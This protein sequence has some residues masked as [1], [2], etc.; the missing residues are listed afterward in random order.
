MP[1]GLNRAVFLDRDGTL[2]KDA[3]YLKDPKKIEII[4]GVG[5]ALMLIAK[6]GF[7]VFLHTN[8]SGVARGYYC[9]KDVNACNARMLELLQLPCDFFDGAC[10]APEHPDQEGGYRKPSARFQLE[11]IVK[12]DLSPDACWMIGDKWIDAQAGLGSG[13]RAALVETGKPI[14]EETKSKALASKVPIHC[15]LLD[16]TKRTLML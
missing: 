10:I 8:Q 5:E 11:T 3:H 9:M 2:I 7:K 4:D 16:F 15:N 1:K 14:G 6:A 13:M 12:F